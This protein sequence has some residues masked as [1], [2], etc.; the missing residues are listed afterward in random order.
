MTNILPFPKKIITVSPCN[1]N[2]TII[3]RVQKSSQL[4][5]TEFN[6][7]MHLRAHGWTVWEICSGTYCCSNADVTPAGAITLND[8]WEIQKQIEHI[9]V[10]KNN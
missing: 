1:R 5:E 10:N 9:R 3:S 2:Q 4:K 7:I 8:A 6:R